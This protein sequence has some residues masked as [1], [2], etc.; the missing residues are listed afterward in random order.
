LFD[1]IVEEAA[2]VLS[3]FLAGAPAGFLT[4]V[5]TLFFFFLASNALEA[6]NTGFFVSINTLYQ[7]A[8]NYTTLY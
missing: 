8:L 3:F 4:T 5:A 2:L 1:W 7:N 6:S